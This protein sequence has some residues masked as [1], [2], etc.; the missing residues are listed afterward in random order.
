M[1]AEDVAAR[2]TQPGKV[3]ARKFVVDLAV[4]SG[5]KTALDFWGGGTS[6]R[7]FTRA[8][9]SVVSA[10]LDRSLWSELDRD[11]AANGYVAHHGRAS[12]VNGVFDMVWADFCG[13][14]SE[15]MERELVAL[16][17]RAVR[18]IAVTILPERDG[19]FLARSRAATI[20][21]WLSATTNLQVHYVVRYQRNRNNQE[22]WLVVLSHPTRGRVVLYPDTVQRNL[23]NPHRRYWASD[24]FHDEY[25]HLFPHRNGVHPSLD[26]VREVLC[27]I[28][29]S[30]FYPPVNRRPGSVFLCGDAC[31]RERNTRLRRRQRGGQYFL[32]RKRCPECGSK[33]QPTRANQRFCTTKHSQ[34]YYGRQ[35]EQSQKRPC[36]PKRCLYCNG[37]FIPRRKDALYCELEHGRLYRESRTKPALPIAA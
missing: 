17:S 3:A 37:A 7:E 28:C 33:F 30:K 34:R 23:L 36:V 6:A 25:P 24:T 12:K 9:L 19:D 10:E 35:W 5:C 20:P 27:E 26:P 15:Q 11:A 18:L 16:K 4:A 13:M 31:L 2:Y 14:V 21:A 8:G 29:G 22:M 32:P 1:R